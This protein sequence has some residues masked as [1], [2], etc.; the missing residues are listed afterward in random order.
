MHEVEWGWLL[1]TRRRQRKPHPQKQSFKGPG[2]SREVLG[3]REG[4]LEG[5]GRLGGG[6]G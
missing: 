6:G 4:G 3:G 2:M 1:C 5:G